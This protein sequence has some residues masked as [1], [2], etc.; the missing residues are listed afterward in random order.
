MWFSCRDTAG[1]PPPA[2]GREEAECIRDAQP[3]CGVTPL[4]FD[5]YEN[6]FFV[7]S[8]P[9]ACAPPLPLPCCPSC[10]RQPS[11]STASST[12]AP[13]QS[14]MLVLSLSGG[15]AAAAAAAAKVCGGVVGYRY[16]AVLCLSAMGKAPP[17]H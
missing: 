4:H 8:G 15:T 16:Q 10:L 6:F 17:L 9:T 5:P 12:L 7:L 1:Q 11:E 13:R 14:S 3:W 2:A